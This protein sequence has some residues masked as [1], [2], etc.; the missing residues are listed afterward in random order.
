MTK[1]HD[2]TA[3]QAVLGAIML[4]PDRVWF[5]VQRQKLQPEAFHDEKNQIIFRTIAALRKSNSIVDVLTVYKRML[6]KGNAERVGGM[7]YLNAALAVIPTVAHAA[8]YIAVLVE[9]YRLRKL[10][11]CF[12]AIPMMVDEGLSSQE[13]TAKLMSDVMAQIDIDERSDPAKLHKQSLEEAARAK[14]TQ[15]QPGIKSF[16]APLNTIMGS[17]LPTNQYL[18]AGRPSDGKTTF[19]QNE[20]VHK[21]VALKVPCA[22]VS[23]EMSERLLR[24]TMAGALADVSLFNFRQGL[25][26]EFGYS[27]MEKAYKDI[28]QSP[29]FITDERMTIE[30]IVSWLSFMVPKH[31]IKLVVLDYI[32]L[33][34]PSR[35]SQTKSRNEQVAE[36][37]CQLKETAKRLN[38]VNLIISQLSRGGFRNEGETPPPPTLE[39]LRDS[40]SLEQDA[41]GVMFVYK[42]PGL[43][44]ENFFSDRDWD[45][46][47]DLAKNRC[48]PIGKL[49][50]KF[51]RRRQRFEDI[52]EYE[53]RLLREASQQPA[54]PKKP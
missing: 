27:R 52:P 43:A 19:T 3:E 38:V 7:E 41:D 23:L 10:N 48:G 35:H 22:F 17:Y 29:I 1:Y 32:Q 50:A 11:S 13:I 6:D 44:W 40:G 46:E 37:S 47:I 36:W 39:A 15:E 8:H 20:V 42:K 28:E 16:M 2:S 31:G 21:A 5:E 26:T 51:V 4:E 49:P 54:L 33:I 14:E 34:K 12:G 30:Q 9:K 45:V 24:D 25:F 18:I 53:K